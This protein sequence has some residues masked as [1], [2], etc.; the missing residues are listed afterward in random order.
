MALMGE[1][2]LLRLCRRFLR[3]RTCQD[4]TLSLKQLLFDP[5]DAE[6]AGGGGRWW[7][8]AKAAP[9]GSWR[10]GAVLATNQWALGNQAA[11][12]Y[13]GLLPRGVPQQGAAGSGKGIVLGRP[14]RVCER[15]IAGTATRLWIPKSDLTEI[16]GSLPNQQA[17]V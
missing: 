14:N 15:R 7:Q 2:H 12:W 13:G 3:L 8:V 5:N 9:G 6:D 17:N 11:A 1:L 4:R 16:C 10:G